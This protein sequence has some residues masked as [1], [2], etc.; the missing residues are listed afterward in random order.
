MLRFLTR[1]LLSLIV[2]SLLLISANAQTSPIEVNL[3][4]GSFKGVKAFANG[5]EHWFGI[6]YAEQPLGSLRFK[7]PVPISKPVTGLQDATNFGPVC[8]QLPSA[9]LGA[10]MGEDCL[11]L[12]VR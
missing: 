11:V 9:T 5:T 4:T 8:P 3:K 2:I 10:P 6:P 7:A 12:N 1:N